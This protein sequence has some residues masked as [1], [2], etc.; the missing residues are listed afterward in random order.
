MKADTAREIK[1]RIST[2]MAIMKSLDVFWL[3]AKCPTRWKVLVFDAVI[4]SKLLYGLE[5]AMLTEGALRKNNTSQ[6]KGLRKILKL[7]T[8]FV[9]RANTNKFVIDTANAAIQG[10]RRIREVTLFSDAYKRARMKRCARVLMSR[11]SQPTRYTSLQEGHKIW[12][13]AQKRIGRPK[14]KWIAEG[15]RD[16]WERVRNPHPSISNRYIAF[17]RSKTNSAHNP[18]IIKTMEELETRAPG[19]LKTILRP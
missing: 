14:D 11:P 8:T 6:L 4:R 3:H 18:V 19:R 10:G 2:C 16:L 9:E 17:N 7:T 5:T 15:M 12:D 1:N 13:F